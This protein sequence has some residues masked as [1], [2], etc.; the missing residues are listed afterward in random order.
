M[1]EPKCNPHD[2]NGINEITMATWSKD[3]LTQD[4]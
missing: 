1:M 4:R 3:E 2:E